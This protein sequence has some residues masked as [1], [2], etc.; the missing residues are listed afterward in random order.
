MT[1]GPA[2]RSGRIRG[3]ATSRAPGPQ[4]SERSQPADRRRR[5]WLGT[6]RREDP[7]RA[8]VGPGLAARFAAPK[9]PG[10]HA[11][12]IGR[13]QGEEAPHPVPFRVDRRGIRV[14]AMTSSGFFLLA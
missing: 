3:T 8:D 5:E 11:V 2:P 10:L 9:G 12:A 4:G 13:D 14:L 6:P 7:G 1:S